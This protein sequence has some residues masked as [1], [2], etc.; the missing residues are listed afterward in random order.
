M[1]KIT[2]FSTILI[3][4]FTLSNP[5]FGFD[6]PSNYN[7]VLEA[8][9]KYDNQQVI[10]GVGEIL[11]NR[12]SIDVKYQ[13][14]IDNTILMLAVIYS[15]MG[16]WETSL[17][18]WTNLITSTS[19]T[20]M[21]FSA[22][23]NRAL[24]NNQLNLLDQAIA[25]YQQALS[26]NPAYIEGYKQIALIY[27]ID[28]LNPE[29]ALE[30]YTNGLIHNPDSSDLL[31]LRAVLYESGGD[32][33]AAIA[34]HSRLI[35]LNDSQKDFY[36]S[37][38][39]MNYY[40]MREWDSALADINTS[41][42][43]QIVPFAQDYVLRGDIY[44]EL[45]I[46]DAAITDY[47]KAISLFSEIDEE[48]PQVYGKL[49]NLYMNNGEFWSAIDNFSE[50]ILLANI[51]DSV[52]EY[53]RG[54]GFCYASVGSYD[55]A[56]VDYSMATYLNP[57]P[58]YYRELGDVYAAGNDTAAALSQ[59]NECIFLRPEP[60]PIDYQKRANLHYAMGN[61][62]GAID[63]YLIISELK[64]YDDRVWSDLGKLYQAAQMY[65]QAV[66][67]FS[68]AVSLMFNDEYY[69]CEEFYFRAYSNMMIGKF[70]EALAD[71][72]LLISLDDTIY[73]PFYLRGSIYESIGD[74]EK[75]A[76][77]YRR[78]A[79]VITSNY[80]NPQLLE[81]AQNALAAAEILDA[82]L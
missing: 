23:Y 34:D 70:S 13:E 11:K 29:K 81:L 57:N 39:A 77:D 68:E 33:Q 58:D 26:Y 27:Q 55:S 48:D 36:Y 4:M 3:V 44:I 16:E 25:D 1:K 37:H 12:D 38:R 46:T 43:L 66:D 64:P 45:G 20:G 69:W 32:Y 42:D 51:W 73:D 82:K 74:W 15:E 24:C 35:E 10:E 28:K 71:L 67:S 56:V 40:K 54:R 21:L 19:D 5:L 62:K 22:Y 79:E 63:D 65:P 6:F 49:A 53:Y 80:E 50:A 31:Y 61:P 72:D 60:D 8:Y 47:T 14:Y 30:T 9:N 7:S 2:L 75:A 76:Q 41:I 59:Y 52:D 17:E 78:L 18:T